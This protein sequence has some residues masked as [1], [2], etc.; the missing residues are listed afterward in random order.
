MHLLWFA[1]LCCLRKNSCSFCYVYQAQAISWLLYFSC[2]LKFLEKSQSIGER[3]RVRCNQMTLLTTFDLFPSRNNSLITSKT[4]PFTYKR[5]LKQM[6]RT[7]FE[8]LC[9]EFC[10]LISTKRWIYSSADVVTESLFSGQKA[11]D[12]IR[13]NSCS[14]DPEI[15]EDTPE[16]II[17]CTRI[18]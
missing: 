14:D 3:W 6:K 11:S 12:K 17:Y 15:Q 13:K 2:E 7:S 18:F 10:S 8:N 1:F 16:L 5:E 9:Q 4:S